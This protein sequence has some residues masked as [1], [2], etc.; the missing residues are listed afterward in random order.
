MSTGDV[1]VSAFTTVTYS[2]F[3]SYGGTVGAWTSPGTCAVGSIVPGVSDF[4]FALRFTGVPRAKIRAATL[5]VNNRGL[6]T[7]VSPL[8]IGLVLQPNVSGF[9]ASTI[10]DLEHS[11][12]KPNAVY[13][14]VEFKLLNVLGL[15]AGLYDIDLLQFIN[16]QRLMYDIR[17]TALCFVFTSTFPTALDNIFAIDNEVSGSAPPQLILDHLVPAQGADNDMSG[18]SDV[19]YNERWFRCPRCDSWFPLSRS[20]RDAERTGLIVCDSGCADLRGRKDTRKPTRERE[21]R[22]WPRL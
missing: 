2:T 5:R 1:L 12:V 4:N 22:L 14:P 18:V 21:D 11:R 9:S 3:A 20:V 16:F 17:F 6:V 19:R 15:P 10:I 13:Y 8:Y 7:S